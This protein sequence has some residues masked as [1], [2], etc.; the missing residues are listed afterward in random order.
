MFLPLVRMCEARG[1]ERDE[2]E[3]QNCGDGI[4]VLFILKEVDLTIHSW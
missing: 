1:N 3:R 2:E 4:R